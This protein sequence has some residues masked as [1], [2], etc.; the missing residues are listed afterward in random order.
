VIS[1]RDIEKPA[2]RMWLFGIIT[3]IEMTLMKSIR[4]KWPDGGWRQLLTAGR[5]DKAG[6]LQRIRKERGLEVELLDCLQ[7]SDKLIISINEPDFLELT[8]FASAKA[9]K[10]AI[11]ELESLRNNLAHGQDI[12]GQDWPPIAR[13][14]RR[15]QEMLAAK[16]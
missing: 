16:I 8:G 12:T 13:L 15:V 9:A 10:R 3:L 11:R 4:I 14:A 1:R 6:E 5:I 7:F 2:V